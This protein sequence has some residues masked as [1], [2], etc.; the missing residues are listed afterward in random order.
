MVRAIV[1]MALALGME[2][3]AE[4]IETEEQREA[5]TKMGCHFGQGYGLGKPMSFDDFVYFLRTKAARR[6][7]V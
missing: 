6:S 3:V 7:M 1:A 2:I 5:L 4:G